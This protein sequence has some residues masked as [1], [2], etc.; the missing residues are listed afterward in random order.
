MTMHISDDDLH[1]YAGCELA[2]DAME[3]VALHLDGC[4]E[5]RA[6]AEPLLALTA[7]LTTLPGQ[8]EPAADGW[9]AL[10]AR[11]VLLEAA[12]APA[13]VPVGKVVSLDAHRRRRA[14]LPAWVPQAAAAALLLG[15]GFGGG[16]LSG[17]PDHR[18]AMLVAAD[19]VATAMSAAIRVQRAG[20]EYV[21]AVA[22]FVAAT[23]GGDS[24]VAA[25][26]REATIAACYGATRELTR[27]PDDDS[28]AVRLFRSASLTRNGPVPLPDTAARAGVMF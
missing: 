4:A 21:A 12:S 9:C 6:R 23:R 1:D 7:R 19:T 13:A 18:E 25:Q 28:A 3:A 14:S 16:R 22:H 8:A 26:G 27:M 5:C 11:L 24:L 2:P 10:H 20:T 15:I 17:T